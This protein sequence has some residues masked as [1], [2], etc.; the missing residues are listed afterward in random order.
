M[1]ATRSK[2][3]MGNADR[4]LK[5]FTKPLKKSQGNLVLATTYGLNKSISKKIVVGLG[6]G[7]DNETFVPVIKLE[8]SSSCCIYLNTTEWTL[9]ADELDTIAEY[10]D[11]SGDSSA[12]WYF[13]HITLGSCNIT[14]TTSHGSKSITFAPVNTSE[15]SDRADFEEEEEEKNAGASNEC[16]KRKRSYQPAIVMQKTTF[17]GL[18]TVFVCVEEQ[19]HRLQRIA[20]NV[21]RC[22]KLYIEYIAERVKIQGVREPSLHRIALISTREYESARAYIK[23]QVEDEFTNNYCDIVLLELTKLFPHYLAVGVKQI[24]EQIAE[25]IVEEE[26][27]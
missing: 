20:H 24:L 15:E 10:L 1:Y 18:K 19:L 22:K 23:T 4:I 6:L 2:A 12:E 26:T 7:V 8:S 16:G 11:S 3:P 21:N 13:E 14:F 5:H 25:E 17:D 9:L 27:N